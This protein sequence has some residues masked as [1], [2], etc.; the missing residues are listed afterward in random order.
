MNDFDDVL[1]LAQV[2]V[3]DLIRLDQAPTYDDLVEFIRK[4]VETYGLANAV[5]HCPSFPGR[6]LD[7]PFL[8]LTYEPDWVA[9]YK[10]SNYVSVDPVFNTGARA[11]LPVDWSTLDRGFD[12][13]VVRLFNE[14]RDAKIGSQGLTIP[15]RGPENG[16]WA[17]FSVTANDRDAEWRG[18][19]R[20]MI[21][22]L[23]LVAH[24]I[25]QK[26][27]LLHASGENIDL[28]ALT[29]RETEAL[30]WTSEG[31][32]VADIGALM[33][34]SPETVKAHLD[35]ARFKLGALNRVHAVAKA[36]RHGIIH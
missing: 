27:C 5:Y 34:I 26:A 2:D 25:H 31:K 36:I 20:G 17:L 16:L 9:H 19:R 18:R 22:D 12:R 29:R 33:R 7:D 23:V 10:K 6:T 4:M 30:A 13:K 15:I 3:R 1:A 8:A 11:L 21:A 32:T 24:F 14:A 28:N 35:S